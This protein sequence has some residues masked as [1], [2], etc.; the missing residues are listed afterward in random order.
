MK[1]VLL[2]SRCPPYPIHLGD[3]LIIWHLA[4]ELSRRGYTID[5]LALYDRADDPSLIAEYEAFF[6]HIELI[7][8]AR[9]GN[10]GYV[11]RLLLPSARFP[12]S[13]EGCFSP[14]LWRT[15]DQY[16][17]RH[18]YDLVHCFGAVSVYEFH[19]L[20]A[21]LPNV[22]TPYESHALY[23]ESAA[24]QGQLRARLRLPFA[25]RFES[26]MFTP[27]DRTVVISAAD[28]AMLRQLQPALHI[29]V[30]ANGI[31]LERFQPSHRGRDAGTLLFVGN[32]EYPP[33][34]DAVRVLVE[35]ALPELRRTIPQARLQLVGLNPPD[36]MRALA[37][38]QIEVTGSVPDVRPYLAQATV[39]V[40][41]L[42]I[43]AGLKNKVLEALAM[44]IPVVATP[45]SVDGIQ[46]R[47]GES[48]IVAPV[49]RIA[50]ET[51]RL[52][53]DDALRERLSRNGRALV[54]AQ[55]SWERTADSYERLYDEIGQPSP[56][57]IM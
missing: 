49:D 51:A 33:N 4:R 18:D 15:I 29:D 1:T 9:R 40:C 45:L 46:V 6:R 57:R 31:E 2:I 52:L 32:Y 41:P 10:G 34:Q 17:S 21:R 25:R 20:F 39:F 37:N 3:R 47:H 53:R 24:R 48:A 42:R 30:I 54:E 7:P 23:L 11:R 38:D 12:A 14:A 16:L 36:W 50:E 44:G 26:F 22:I 43:G 55:Y 56:R 8:E 5:L 27:Y 13:A 28:R 35:Q 19:P